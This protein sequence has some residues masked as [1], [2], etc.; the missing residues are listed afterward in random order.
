MKRISL[1]QFLLI[2]K[3]D[4]RI[5]TKMTPILGSE[6]STLTM[7]D[8]VSFIRREIAIVIVLAVLSIFSFN[9]WP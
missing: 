8:R 6:V 2:K 3:T 7:A 4:S 1:S 5:T 9:V